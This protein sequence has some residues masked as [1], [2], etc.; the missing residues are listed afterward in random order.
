MV[1]S[2]T[3]VIELCRRSI[4]IGT[5]AGQL[6]ELES[7][8]LQSRTTYFPAQR[9]MAAVKRWRKLFLNGALVNFRCFSFYLIISVLPVNATHPDMT[10]SFVLLCFVCVCVCVCVGVFAFAFFSWWMNKLQFMAECAQRAHWDKSSFNPSTFKRA[11]YG[12]YAC[13]GWFL[14]W[15]VFYFMAWVL[16]NPKP[17]PAFI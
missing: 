12:L 11:Q 16:A 1:F 7:F 17:K 15:F 13:C 4:Q 5:T 10:R 8:P 2:G 14:W 3:V 9:W 6:D